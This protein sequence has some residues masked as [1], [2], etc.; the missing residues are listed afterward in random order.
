MIE[1][2]PT[3]LIEKVPDFIAGIGGVQDLSAMI[4]DGMSLFQSF[5]IGI[6]DELATEGGELCGWLLSE[7]NRGILV[8]A[9]ER[10]GLN[11]GKDAL[12]LDR[13]H[14]EVVAIHDFHMSFAGT[15]D[16]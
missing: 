10:V 4:G 12:L 8:A 16:D 1:V 3:E 9:V 11:S 5:L 15:L 14:E 2:S 7:L 13:I 6:R